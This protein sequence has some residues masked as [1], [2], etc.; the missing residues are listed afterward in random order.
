MSVLYI[1]CIENVKFIAEIS[2]IEKSAKDPKII[3]KI[4][5]Y[6]YMCVG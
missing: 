1:N 5:I 4:Y 3:I 6:I 2:E